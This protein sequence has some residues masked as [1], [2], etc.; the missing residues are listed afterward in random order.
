MRIKSMRLTRPTKQSRQNLEEWQQTSFST[1]PSSSLE[2]VI[3]AALNWII[4]KNALLFYF[5]SLK[6]FIL[7]ITVQD[8]V[9]IVLWFLFIYLFSGSNDY[10]NNFLQPF[11]ADAQQYTPEEFV[12]LLV[13]TL[14]HQLSVNISEPAK[15]FFSCKFS[16]FNNHV[17]PIYCS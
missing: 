1:R 14:D 2:L 15:L 7:T 12:E 11:L 16:K 13:S 6:C 8:G 17:R 5:Y 9:T 4:H 10:V 3:L